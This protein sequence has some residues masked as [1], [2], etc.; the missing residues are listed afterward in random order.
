[1]SVPSGYFDTLEIPVVEDRNFTDGDG[2][3]ALPVVIINQAFARRLF[4]NL[5]PVGQSIVRFDKNLLIVG[6]MVGGC[7]PK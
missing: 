4:H 7:S 2:A 5:D 1:M 6:V 3:D